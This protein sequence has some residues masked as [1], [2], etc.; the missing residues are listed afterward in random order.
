MTKTIESI[1]TE[2]LNLAT[3]QRDLGFEHKS[4]I[5]VFQGVS[6]LSALT[7]FLKKCHE[8]GLLLEV[9]SPQ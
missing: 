4:P 7:T 3:Q 1:L 9:A 6:D 8:N 2:E 5:D